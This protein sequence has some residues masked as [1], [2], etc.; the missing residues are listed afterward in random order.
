MA[1]SPRRAANIGRVEDGKDNRADA[2]EVGVVGDDDERN[3]DDVVL[4]VSRRRR[5]HDEHVHHVLTVL[6]RV[7]ASHS[8]TSVN[9]RRRHWK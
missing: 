5:P 1:R 3:G 7:T 6:L 2:R 4:R 9:S 8:P